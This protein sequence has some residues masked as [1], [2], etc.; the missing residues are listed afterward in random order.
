MAYPPRSS[1]NSLSF[2]GDFNPCSPEA[3]NVLALGERGRPGRSTAW[4]T[5]NGAFIWITSLLLRH[6]DRKKERQREKMVECLTWLLGWLRPSLPCPSAPKWHASSKNL[7]NCQVFPWPSKISLKLSIKLVGDFRATQELH[8][9]EY[10]FLSHPLQKQRHSASANLPHWTTLSIVQLLK[11]KPQQVPNLLGATGL[12]YLVCT[13]S[14]QSQVLFLY[15]HLAQ[16]LKGPAL[17]RAVVLAT[18]T[19]PCW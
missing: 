7:V 15:D 6:V 14:A 3:G 12:R 5:L 16:Y 8:R 4:N 10:K 2:S 18:V 13:A 11:K 17:R 1:L 19:L 9:N